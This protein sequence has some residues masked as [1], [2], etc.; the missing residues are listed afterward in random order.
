[1]KQQKI[2]VAILLSIVFFT[3]LQ[4]ESDIDWQV[5][6]QNTDLTLV[7]YEIRINYIDAR[8]RTT[9]T[10]ESD[11]VDFTGNGIS[12]LAGRYQES[13]AA[14]RSGYVYLGLNMQK[15]IDEYDHKS[16]Y[17]AGIVG[18]EFVTGNKMAKFV[19]GLEGG[20][21][22]IDSR[23]TDIESVFSYDAEPYIGLRLS[24]TDSLNV[25]LRV[26]VRGFIIQHA[27]DTFGAADQNGNEAYTINAQIGIGYFLP[28]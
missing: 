7:G 10:T 17:M 8:G 27:E 24:P 19:Y 16:N 28:N 13:S 6:S 9:L 18:F 23:T 11:K 2:C 21:G 12:V 22:Y 4:A 15:W 5:P 14:F 26:G 20:L 1:M 25:N 3:M